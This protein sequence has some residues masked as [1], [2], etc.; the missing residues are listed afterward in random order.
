MDGS[1]EEQPRASRQVRIVNPEGMHLRAVSLLI[2]LA[3]R[4]QCSIWVSNHNL[5][6]DAKT[7]PLELLALGA[8]PGDQLTIEALG[9][10]A[11]E[12]VEA[13]ARLIENRFEEWSAEV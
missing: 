11:Q 1:L 7:T 9:P 5:R 12:A 4:F 10:D 8:Q 6:A 13:I 3:R 2:Q